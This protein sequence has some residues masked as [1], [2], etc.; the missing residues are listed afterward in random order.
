MPWRQRYTVTRRKCHKARQTVATAAL[1]VASEG[2][3]HQDLA[4]TGLGTHDGGA[5]AMAA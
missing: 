3:G 2:N 4:H 1:S 5:S